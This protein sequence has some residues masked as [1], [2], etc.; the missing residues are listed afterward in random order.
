METALAG[1]GAPDFSVR[2]TGIGIPADKL[3]QIFESFGQLSDSAHASFGGTGLGLAISRHLVELMGGR[4]WAESREGRGST[5]HFSLSLEIAAAAEAA[6]PA[7]ELPAGNRSSR[8]LKSCWP[9]TR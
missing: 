4:I 6:A 9:R 3:E 1:L 2:D 5:F 7:P 8:G